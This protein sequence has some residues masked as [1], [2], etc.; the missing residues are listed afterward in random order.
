MIFQI[1]HHLPAEVEVSTP[2]GLIQIVIKICALVISTEGPQ[3][4]PKWRHKEAVAKSIKKIYRFRFSSRSPLWMP[5]GGNDS[6]RRIYKV[7]LV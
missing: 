4:G 1:L 2:L 5:D 7:K 3:S 6:N